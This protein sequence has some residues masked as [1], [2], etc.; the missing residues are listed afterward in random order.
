MSS[1][2]D[3]LTIKE[4]DVLTLT[5][6]VSFNAAAHSFSASFLDTSAYQVVQTGTLD[7]DSIGLTPSESVTAQITATGNEA[8]GDYQ[9]VTTDLSMTESVPATAKTG[10]RVPR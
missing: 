10:R 8:T 4:T 6:S 2:G 7:N 3:N 9:I 5:G 1:T